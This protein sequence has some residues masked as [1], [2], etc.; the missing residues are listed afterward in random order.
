MWIRLLLLCSCAAVIQ[1]SAGAQNTDPRD[2]LLRVRANVTDTLARLPKYMCSLT[3]DRAQYSPDPIHPSSCD[4]MAAQRKKG[5][6]KPRLAET[7]RV[8]LDVAIAATNEIYSWPGEDRF[9][10]RNAF[11]LV[12]QGA[13]Q[14]GGYSTFLTTIFAGEDANFSYNGETEWDGRKLTEFGFQVPAERSRYFFGNR[15]HDVATGYEGTFL[16]DPNTGDLVRLLVRTGGLP[17][18]SGFCGATTTLDYSRVRL[19]DSEFLLPAKTTLEVLNID[20]SEL[21]NSTEYTSCHEFRGESAI[22]FDE[23]APEVSSDVP[24]KVIAPSPLAA[25][26]GI[27]FTVIFTEA[28]HTGTAAAGD[29]VQAA[30]KTAI[31]DPASQ[32]LFAPQGAQVTARIVGL[33]HFLERPAFVQMLVRLES[34]NVDGK[35]VPLT[36]TMN[37]RIHGKSDTPAYR[38]DITPRSWVAFIPPVDVRNDPGVGT[39]E[40]L[41]PKSNL[42]IQSGLESNWVTAAPCSSSVDASSSGR[43]C[44]Q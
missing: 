17:A 33:E 23:P 26:A 21:R 41:D 39:L 43:P 28:I 37:R 19:N 40:F 16:A 4:G 35:P 14:S 7:D 12:R 29:R 13:L 38:L 9:N 1:A 25:P 30:L 32:V 11:D 34:V 20:G 27:E 22:K 2:L 42:V 31:R 18:N 6:L 44:G 24:A 8:R 15:R 3:I 5:Q 10:D 36:S